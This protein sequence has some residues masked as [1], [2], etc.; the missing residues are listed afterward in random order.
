MSKHIFSKVAKI[1]EEVRLAE[2]NKVELSSISEMNQVASKAEQL[3]NQ[4]APLT[5]IFNEASFAV[6]KAEKLIAEAN[7]LYS[8]GTSVGY[9]FGS[10]VEDLGLNPRQY[11][12]YTNMFDAM[13][14]MAQRISALETL[15]KKYR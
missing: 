3:A 14:N 7:K 13:N 4:I 8:D 6:D 12:E 10:K 15:A 1:G 5:K 11:K 2:S 9:A